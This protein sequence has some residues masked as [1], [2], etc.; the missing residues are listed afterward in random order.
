VVAAAA[1][2]VL[3]LGACSDEDTPPGGSPP[4]LY[5]ETILIDPTPTTTP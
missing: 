2:A 4:T 3:G 1:L 5:E